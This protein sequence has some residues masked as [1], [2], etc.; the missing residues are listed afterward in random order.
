MIHVYTNDY[1]Y[2]VQ[3]YRM[4]ND[5]LSIYVYLS[6]KLFENKYTLNKNPQKMSF[7]WEIKPINN[8]EPLKWSKPE[9]VITVFVV[10]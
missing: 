8:V 5:A 4:Q 6:L 7:T 1:Y 3:W 10:L 9:P 2:I